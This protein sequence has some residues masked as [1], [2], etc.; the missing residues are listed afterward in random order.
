[1]FKNYLVILKIKLEGC[2]RNLK[3]YRV[4]IK[5]QMELLGAHNRNVSEQFTH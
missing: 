1:M 3:K 5:C 4:V 2:E